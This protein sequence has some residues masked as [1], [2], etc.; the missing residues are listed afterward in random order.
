MCFMQDGN[1]QKLFKHI[2][3]GNSSSSNNCKN[4]AVFLYRLQGKCHQAARFSKNGEDMEVEIH[5][6]TSDMKGK[7]LA[8]DQRKM[9][10]ELNTQTKPESFYDWRQGRNDLMKFWI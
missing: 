9:K 5:N 4:Y 3:N 6:N 10:L 1:L 2:S 7:L 8:V